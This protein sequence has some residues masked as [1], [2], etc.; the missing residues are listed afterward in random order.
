MNRPAF[1]KCTMV[2]KRIR[3]ARAINDCL[4][5]ARSIV[6]TSR[7]RSSAVSKWVDHIASTANY[8]HIVAS[9]SAVAVDHIAST[10]HDVHIVASRSVVAVDHIASTANYV[11]SVA[12]RSAAAAVGIASTSRVTVR[13][14]S[15]ISATCVPRKRTLYTYAAIDDTMRS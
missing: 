3:I 8:V 5:A 9:R 1:T 7:V 12:S 2:N 11:Q 10:V 13:R 15:A 14:N 6:R 4:Y